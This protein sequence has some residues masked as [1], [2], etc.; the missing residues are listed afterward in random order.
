MPRAA[1]LSIHARVRGTRPDVL[2]NPTL[3]GIWGPRFSNYVVAVADVPVFTLGR[4]P[5][6]PAGQRRAV[7]TADR[8]DA[9]LAGRR[10]GYGDAGDAMGVNPNSL[11]YATTTG[12]VL[13]RWEGARQPVVW[14]IPPPEM[15]AEEARLELAR[16]FLHVCGPATP[17][18]F[19]MW[20]GIGPREAAAAFRGLEAT[21]VPVR[22]PI[23]EGSTLASDEPSFRAPPSATAGVRLL[24]SGDPYFLLW[25]ADREVL[26]P[27]PSR[28]AELWTSRV[29]PGALL[30]A[31]EIAGTWRRDQA[32]VAISPWHRLSAAERDAIEEEVASL[33]LPG[34]A[35]RPFAEWVD[36]PR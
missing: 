1:L 26:V 27:D 8:L 17:A 5:D 20:A 15:G 35:R 23:G 22:T 11:R 32:R 24:P 9:F 25:G 4:F 10:M 30:V 33:P 6:D 21:L 28:R 13:I 14:M 12:R 36:D 3:V 19:G 34:L 18:A 16:R 2:D 7:D 31:G 29:W